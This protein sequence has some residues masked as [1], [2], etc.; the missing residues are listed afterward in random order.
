M[1]GVVMCPCETDRTAITH[2]ALLCPDCDKCPAHCLCAGDECT[3]GFVV[4]TFRTHKPDCEV[5]ITSREKIKQKKES[6]FDET[7]GEVEAV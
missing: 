7:E 6:L 5:R 2:R 3:C 1:I 4:D